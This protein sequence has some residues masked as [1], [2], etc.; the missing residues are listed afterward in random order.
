MTTQTRRWFVIGAYVLAGLA[1]AKSSFACN[2]APVAYV[3]NWY[4]HEPLGDVVSFDGS[5][6]YDPDAGD[7]LNYSWTFP[8]EAYSIS[9]QSSSTSSCRF[10]TA[11]SYYVYLYVT[12][13]HNAT[14]YDY[15]YV[16]VVEVASVTESGTG[17]TS[18][19]V[20]VNGSANLQASPY[21]STSWPSGKPTWSITSQPGGA[22][23]S[24]TPGSGAAT[25]NNMTVPGLY[26]AKAVCGSSD[27]GAS[28]DVK[29]I[30]VQIN[31][32][33]PASIAVGGT[34]SLNCTPQG[35]T[36]GSFTWSKVSGPG[37][38]TF[39]PSANAE[40]PYFSASAA[41]TYT[42]QVQYTKNG[43]TVTKTSGTITVAT[44]AVDVAPASGT[45][46]YV[47]A[48]NT[49][50][51]DCTPSGIT[52][53]TYSWSKDSGPG[54]VTFSNPTAK[55]PTF[56]ATQT[57]SYVVRVQYTAGGTT[58]SDTS[59]TITVFAIDALPSSGTM[60]FASGIPRQL[61]STLSPT[62]LSG[63]TYNWSKASGTGS[64]TFSNTAIKDPTFSATEVGN[65]TARAQYIIGGVIA[66]DITS[67]L[68]VFDAPVTTPSSAA[69]VGLGSSLQLDCTP[70]TTGGTY[71]WSKS[72]GPGTVTFSDSATQKDPTFTA[73][74]AGAYVV[75]VQYTLGGASIVR[76]S[77]AITVFDVDVIT[78]SSFPVYVGAGSPLQLD[79]TPTTTG[80]TYNWFQIN[81]PGTGTF[82][83]SSARNPTF[84]A[85]VPGSYV[86][87]VQYTIGNA[88]VGESSG[89]ITVFAIDALPS[90]GTMYFASGIP[91]QL[92]ATLSPTGL[93]G[94]TYNW[95]KASG[96]GTVTFSNT[97]I[98]NPTFSAAEV[99]NYTAR[100]QYIIG[101]VIA[102]DITS[103]LTVF[104]APVTTPSSAAY[105][106]LGSSLQLDCT[107]T[108]TGG[109]YS[110]SKSSGPGTVTFSDSA[111][112]KDPTFA[113][114]AAG[115]YA[116]LVQYTLGGASI[117]RGSSA[118]TVFDVDVTTPSSFPAY[119]VAG[120]PLQLDC[121]PTTTGGTYNW[122]QINGPGTGTFSDS[123]ARNPTFTA[124]VP[125]SYAVRV[126][127]TIGNAS[128]GESSGTITVFAIDALPSSGTMY[129]ASGIPRQ[130]D[131]TLSPTGLSGGTYNW[132]KAS[133]PGSVTFS[134]TAIKNPTF[135]AT[136]VGNYTARAQY[137]I[138]GVIADDITSTLTVFD[139]PVTTPSSA[140]Y[141]GLGSSLQ[142]DCTPTTTGGTYS[143]SKGSGPGTVTFSDSAAQKDPTFT[144]SAP[145]AYVALVQYTLG[146]ATIVRG[147]S[148]ITVFDVDVITPSSFPAYVGAG[149]PLQLDCT[150]TT[151]GGTY[152]WFQ[153]NG[154]GTGTFSDSSAPNPTF[155]ATV[156]GSYAVRVQY[157][158]GNASVGESSGTITVLGVDIST[159][160]ASQTYVARPVSLTLDCGPDPG[161]IPG[162]TYL[163]TVNPTTGASI[164]NATQKTANFLGSLPGTYNVQV[165][166]TVGTVTVNSPPK[167]IAVVSVAVDAPA[168]EPLSIKAGDLLT[169]SCT[170]LPSGADGNDYNWA[171]AA[172]ATVTPATERSTVFSSAEAGHYVAS[173]QCQVE[174]VPVGDATNVISVIGVGELWAFCGT[175]YNDT[176]LYVPQGA[177]VTLAAF[178]SPEYD[179]WP[180]NTP[181]WSLQGPGGTLVPTQGTYGPSAFLSGLTEPGTYT[182]TASCGTSTKSIDV[183]AV[184]LDLDI[185]GVDESEEQ[186]PG[187]Y[188]VVNGDDDDS[189]G[190]SDKFEQGTVQNEDDLLALSLSAT[191]VLNTG[192]A[193][194]EATAGSGNIKVWI[195]PTKGT[196]IPLPKVWILS[197][198][199]IP[200]QVYVEG[201]SGS[202]SERDVVLRLSWAPRPGA[203]LTNSQSVALTVPDVALQLD[204]GKEHRYV[205]PLQIRQV[206]VTATCS[207]G[208][209][210][211]T[212]SATSGWDPCGVSI[213]LDE[214]QTLP[215]DLSTPRQWDLTDPCDPVPDS[216]YV[217][218]TQWGTD[219]NTLDLHLTWG[220]DSSHVTANEMLS[221]TSV[222][223]RLAPSSP[224][225]QAGVPTQI[226]IYVQ[227]GMLDEGHAILRITQGEGYVRLWADEAMTTPIAY[228]ATP[229]ESPWPEIVWDL[230]QE[231]IPSSVYAE[232]LDGVE[233]Q[234][235][236]LFELS[237]RTRDP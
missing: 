13:N 105:V 109:T 45:T 191:P 75:L 160:S 52:G 212:L 174:G 188:V 90:S 204:T 38:V 153:I 17:A 170:P 5:G 31:T 89:T 76:G 118:I 74:A 140:A 51:L 207:Q 28:I 44:V 54:T 222:R 1:T 231:G 83:D 70:T 25:L 35:D 64:V 39:S 61:D 230:S 209:G 189:N 91:R 152:N 102:D 68:T 86:V 15:A 19:W 215:L 21:P 37:T 18:I 177:A 67:T 30:D 33:F 127:Y 97:A 48:G 115:A 8:A 27:D 171:V 167:T 201:V 47:K 14:D 234:G 69:Y 214:G 103:T 65:Y 23:A 190:V 195:G 236:A 206:P 34:L 194:L 158:I 139:A 163:W 161:E 113:A 203:E 196:Q 125:G 173:V 151:T 132:S 93:S 95:S 217:Q 57:G 135:S 225:F 82:S 148:A 128:V 181:T 6:S 186:N 154:P 126:Q 145:G 114:S 101:G 55:N 122:F 121:T 138:G 26:R 9:G 172:P 200:A 235:G 178:P 134:D 111:T 11:G 147:S 4:K 146:G 229:P 179:D 41:G 60:Y 29:A 78:P 94:G 20:P 81:G 162:G 213:W 220:P 205:N 227:P 87:R 131:A 184:A 211:V 106:G 149:S 218:F 36:G 232:G 63:G 32:S 73:S 129:F 99:G 120:S 137:I 104:D 157:T 175:D 199:S 10:N 40:D 12:D 71:S 116:V 7:Y 84:T 50:Q 198:E 3:S 143:W 208:F 80:G 46:T 96:T 192:V 56:S 124:T 92:D 98:K 142:L 193:K 156:P 42:V 107:P 133:G 166:Y 197:S 180:A 159:P 2:H 123:S 72:S 117:V 210:I 219:P 216:F 165:A 85:T 58:V 228:S 79:C 43:A 24:V 183:I 185:A 169:L 77:S 16:Y 110:W 66:D 112:Q 182:V 100:A 202:T 141:V 233:E 176:R 119:V 168:T 221:L 226:G 62:G 224:N 150:P 59:G 155:T 49:R 164:S 108:T 53:G 136:E 22:S 144:A 187:G 237:F 130:L 88:S 223:L